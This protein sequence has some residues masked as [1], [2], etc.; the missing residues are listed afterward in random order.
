MVSPFKMFHRFSPIDI[1]VFREDI[2]QPAT[3]EEL[4]AL[5]RK[6]RRACLDAIKAVHQGYINAISSNNCKPFATDTG[7]RK[8]APRTARDWIPT[9]GSFGTRS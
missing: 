7:N 6:I 3:V 4:E 1:T 2:D 5:S 8:R 9:A